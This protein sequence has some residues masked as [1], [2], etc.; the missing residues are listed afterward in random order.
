MRNPLF[1]L[2]IT[3]FAY[4]IVAFARGGGGGGLGFL[5]VIAFGIAGMVAIWWA[6]FVLSSI[7]INKT[8]GEK[9]NSDKGFFSWVVF[10]MYGL[11]ISFIIA[12]IFF[13][14]KIYY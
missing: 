5:F 14:R 11:P 13:D 3:L 1:L 8:I 4:P 7:V 6:I 12:L 10:L 2:L 9:A